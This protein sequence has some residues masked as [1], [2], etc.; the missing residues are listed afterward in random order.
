MSTN[1]EEQEHSFETQKQMYTDMIMMKPNWQMAGIYADEG[2]TGTIAKKRPGFMKMIEDCRKGKIDIIITKSVSRFSRNNLDCL[3]YVRELKGMG[4][5]II[6]EKEGINTLQVSSELLI[7]LF[8]GLSQ[9][10]SES[11]SMNVKMGI[12]HNLKNG[13]VHFRY[14]SFLG[15]RKG[16]DG[17]PEIVPEEAEII[18]RI[19]RDYL[20]GKTLQAIAQELNNDGIPKAN[21]KT[22]WK[23]ANIM[24]ILRN[25]KY[26]GDALLQKTYVVDCIS[27]KTKKNNGE[28]PMYYVENSHPAIIERSL[29]DKVQ[30]KIARRSSK[31]KTKETGTKTALGKYSGKYALS[32]MLYCGECGKPYRRITW[33]IRGEHKV[34]WRCV[35]RLDYGKKYCKCS[36]SVEETLLHNAISE[37]ITRKSKIEGVSP[38]KI[39]RHIQSYHASQD[40]E[41]VLA[42]QN[43]LKELQKKFDS[44]TSIDIEQAD[45]GE[46]DEQF[47]SLMSEIH[48]LEDE[49]AEIEKEKSK[50]EKSSENLEQISA[51]IEGLKNHPVPYDDIIVRQLIYYIKVVSKNMIQIYFKDGTTLDAEI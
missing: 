39:I 51:I 12:R 35:S 3:M 38:E 17:N 46:F 30:E 5:P 7:A 41:S 13:K 4:I 29:F 37:A 10:E 45:T 20:L 36:P 25:E 42:K 2:I 44:L 34:V 50:W 48:R 6:F 16:A 18:K 43:R 26:K 22:N 33:N 21:G 19:Y 24:S 40:T 8:G 32:E 11:I 31:P 49:L 15:Y 9:A 27:K 28:L 47:E 14:R 23:G 1:R